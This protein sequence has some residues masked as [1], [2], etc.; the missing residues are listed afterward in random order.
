MFVPARPAAVRRSP[1]ACSL[2]ERYGMPVA[3]VPAWNA[4]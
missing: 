3:A 2:F 4:V 1:G